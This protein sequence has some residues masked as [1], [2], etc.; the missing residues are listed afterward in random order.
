MGAP[1]G[2]DAFFR[3]WGAE[4]AEGAE[5][6]LG[7]SRAVGAFLVFCFS[8]RLCVSAVTHPQVLC[9]Q[10]AFLGPGARPP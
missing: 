4:A 10:W 5:G 8:P 6:G 9:F 2:A 7:L 3:G 1:V